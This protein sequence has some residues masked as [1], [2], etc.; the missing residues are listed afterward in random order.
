[1]EL[2]LSLGTNLGKRFYNLRRA[3]ELLNL[4]FGSKPVQKSGTLSSSAEGFVGP[5]FLNN[6][7]H[8]RLD[9]SAD[10]MWI[11]RECQ[12][13]ERKMGRKAHVMEFDQDGNRIYHSRRIDIDILLIDNQIIDTP[14]LT[15]PHPRLKERFF[16]YFPLRQ[17]LDRDKDS[18]YLVTFVG[19]F[20]FAGLEEI[21]NN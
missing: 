11:L 1:M 8:Y 18:Q 14:E 19:D 16:M 5:R 4:S 7:L 15:V 2:F 6:C 17:L 13:V 20:K 12:K 3:E 9:D 10:P 21:N